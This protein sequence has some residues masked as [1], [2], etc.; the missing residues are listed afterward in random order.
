M[1]K[2]KKLMKIMIT[3]FFIICILQEINL[4]YRSKN[5]T[6]GINR[7]HISYNT[8]TLGQNNCEIITENNVMT[9]QKYNGSANT[10]IINEEVLEGNGLAIDSNAFLECGNLETILIDKNSIENGFEI[11]NFK[12][13][14]QY[15]D[16]Q[17]VEYKNIQNY[18]E[19]YKKYIEL[20]DEE[21]NKIGIIP[22]KY[23]IPIS[24]MYAQSMKETYNLSENNQI[25]IPEEFDLRDSINIKVENQGNTNICYAYAS[26]TAVETNLA[27]RHN[28][29]VD[30]SEGHL[31]NNTYGN[32]SGGTFV[33][34]DNAYYRNKVGPIYQSDWIGGSDW[35]SGTN[36]TANR[37]VERTT[38]FPTINKSNIYSQE[39]L[40]TVRS[41]IK[42][43]IIQYGSLYA[44]ISST[45]KRNDD[46]IYVLNAKFSEFP[47]HAVSIIG[48]DDNFSKENFPISNRPT[49]D[50]AYLALNS[51]GNSWGDG[52]CFWISYEDT[53]VETSL[54][55]VTSVDTCQENINIEN[56][57]ITDKN[58]ETKISYKITK[59][60][61]SQI[62]INMNINELKNNNEQVEI[63][64]FDSNGEDIVNDVQIFGNKI[65]N[66]KAKI[67]LE[68]DTAK[69]TV[70][71]YLIKIKYDEEIIVV[72]IVIK[73]D[74]YDF[75]INT[76]GSIK[77]TGYCGKDKKIEIPKEFFGYSVTG[78]ENRALI[79]NDLESITIYE[80][81]T[82]IGQNIINESVIIYGQTGTYVEHYASENGYIF[83]DLNNKV[84]E[85]QGWYF[86]SENHKLYILENSSTKEYDY[87]KNIIRKVEV[88]SPVQQ[89]FNNQ[90]EGYE[91]LKE[92]ILP[93]T[94]VSIGE[95]AF[96]E[97]NNLITINL[98]INITKI[99]AQTFYNCQKLEN[100]N[101]PENVTIIGIGAFYGCSNLKN[102]NIPNG[103]TSISDYLFYM[104]TSLQN[105]DIPNTVTS[106]GSYAFYQCINLENIN[107]P[108]GLTNIGDAAFYQCKNLNNLGLPVTLNS[109]GFNAFNECIINKIAEVGNT[110]IELPNI[111]KRAVNTGDI[112]N[113]GSGISIT[114]GKLD[115]EKS[116]INITPGYGQITINISNGKLKGLKVLI[117]VS[118]EIEYSTNYW[119]SEEVT[120]TLYIGKGEHIVN[121]GGEA[122]YKFLENGEFE[123]EYININRENKK[124]TAK[125]ENIDKILPQIIAVEN[126][127]EQGF[128]QSITATISDEQ[129]GLW[130]K[131]SIGYAWSTSNTINPIDW[132]DVNIPA[133]T[134]ETK[135]M[136]FDID[137]SGMAGKYYLWIYKNAFYDMAA[138]GFE[139]KWELI[140]NEPYYLGYEPILQE[141]KITNPPDKIVYIE[142]E[143]FKKEGLVVVKKYH[144]GTEIEI[145]DY[146]VLDGEN[147]TKEKTFVTISYI[148]NEIT[149]TT[150]QDITV[151][152]KLEVTSNKYEIQDEYISKVQPNTSISELKNQLETT[153]L[154]INIYSKDDVLQE[155]TA[156][157]ETGMKLELKTTNELIALTIVVKGDSN[158]DGNANIKDI[159]EINKHRLKKVE[160]SGE[161]LKA[162]D[163][164]DDGVSDIKDILQINKY[165]LGKINELGT[166]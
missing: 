85:G 88:K 154:E 24:A 48:W 61:N 87:L 126:K 105:I 64:V 1:K 101:I 145:L 125:V 148:E 137:V 70:G 163:V 8:V 78:I 157:I 118:G 132:T 165:R 106:I 38:S 109:I 93:E 19:A 142:G 44:S 130:S 14:N 57:V 77:I 117:I 18:S 11:N 166:I 158:G 17:Y 54:K 135:Q 28:D 63:S 97:C 39:E 140:S 49:T 150:I 82:E 113:C 159:L 133:F 86:D 5:K 76:D 96:S 71:E 69:L 42:T 147:L 136:S 129:A 34:A 23:E 2:I 103:I 33:N 89:I 80:N 3:V 98:P 51:W 143:A 153:A 21:K 4:Y 66:N 123:F 151:E 114:N 116:K 112:L 99:E 79:N 164:N 20:S 74:T 90:F 95:K 81:I 161:Y 115:T 102:I 6:A 67:L 62:E 155:S 25:N 138:N 149:E 94:I 52:G 160:L 36:I 58:N 29:Y 162:S 100:I 59:G 111:I 32:I 72:P 121:N 91:N 108:E 10:I 50:G 107:I 30:L 43:H 141:I 75:K 12:I 128:I 73:I 7:D 127:D 131:S 37:Y 16:E 27:L 68:I 120:A 53:W 84:I 110:E 35:I 119:T 122:V 26:L 104:C 56:I 139:K 15:E 40:N 134:D 13:N 55:G 144:N 83:I 92:V 156:I 47:D 9:I 146:T 22:E 41:L 46:G 45:I 65:E 152:E 31:A 60:I 124:V